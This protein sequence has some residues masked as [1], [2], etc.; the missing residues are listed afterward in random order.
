MPDERRLADAH[1]ASAEAL[2]ARKNDVL[3]EICRA[4]ARSADHGEVV[5]ESS[6]GL[7]RYFGPHSVVIFFQANGDLVLEGIALPI[8][9]PS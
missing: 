2:V 9:S 5:Q 3:A 1:G 7:Q 8:I 4:I 6:V